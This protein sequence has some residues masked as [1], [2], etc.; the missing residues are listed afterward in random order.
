MQQSA[1]T[2]LLREG[3]FLDEEDPPCP[4]I[5]MLIKEGSGRS[6]VKT[7]THFTSQMFNALWDQ[8]GVDYTWD[9]NRQGSWIQ[10]HHKGLSVHL[11]L[12]SEGSHHMGKAWPEF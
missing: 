2:Y 12:C 7:M 1:G 8:V 4:L 11:A 10:D 9:G 5:D 6:I 3:D